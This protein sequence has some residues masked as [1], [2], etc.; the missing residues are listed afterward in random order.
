MFCVGEGY[1]VY[2]DKHILTIKMKKHNKNHYVLPIEFD[3]PKNQPSTSFTN[4]KYTWKVKLSAVTKDA[5]FEENFEIPVYHVDD[6]ELVE[7]PS[8]PFFS[9]L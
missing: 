1:N 2:E 5:E 9:D 4:P 7:R 6:P 3:I 8:K